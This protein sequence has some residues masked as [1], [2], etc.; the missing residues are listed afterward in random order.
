MVRSETLLTT[1][2]GVYDEDGVRSLPCFFP[3]PPPSPRPATDPL[4]F[5]TPQPPVEDADILAQSLPSPI[6]KRLDIS[7]YNSDTPT[8]LFAQDMPLLNGLREAGFAVDS[9]PDGA[10][11]VQKYLHRGGGYYIDVGCSELIASGK[12]G[13]RSGV[14][15]KEVKAHSVVL[16]KTNGGK[17]EEGK[18]EEELPATEVVFATGY[19]NMLTTAHNIFGAEALGASEEEGRGAV[20][21]VWGFDDEGEMRGMWRGTGHPGFW[22]MGGNLALCRFYSRLLALQVLGAELGMKK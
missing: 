19:K 21:E 13:V 22:F 14:E 20:G 4:F 16:R 3:S 12:I 9:G 2:K 5:T 1:L 17:E 8:S 18:E 6:A 11:L 15:V 10:G 7:T